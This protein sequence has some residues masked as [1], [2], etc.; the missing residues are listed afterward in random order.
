[1]KIII[2]QLSEEGRKILWRNWKQIKGCGLSGESQG[3][4]TRRILG[5]FTDEI[6]LGQIED[7]WPAAG[8]ELARF[9]KDH[10]KK[11]DWIILYK[12]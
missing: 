5:R 4:V 10:L 3:M 7:A 2:Y 1:M 6:T 9:A 8:R 11:D 12:G